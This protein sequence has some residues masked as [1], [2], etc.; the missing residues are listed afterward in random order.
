MRRQIYS[1]PPEPQTKTLLLQVYQGFEQRLDTATKDRGHPDFRAKHSTVL[2]HI[3]AEGTRLST[4]ADRAA[5]SRPA[6]LQLVDELESKGYV[7]R[8]PDPYDRRAKL[9]V[10]TE[11]GRDQ[12]SVA[13]EVAEDL[14]QQLRELLGRQQYRT[15]RR[16]LGYL[17]TH[18]SLESVSVQP[19]AAYAYQQ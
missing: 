5:M 13:I 10:P 16:I 19:R 7:R 8:E 1:P 11:K 4:L 15:L 12:I 9:I 17:Y 18:Y 3:D 2:A 6:M 14:E